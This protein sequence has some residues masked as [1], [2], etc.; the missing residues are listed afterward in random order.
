MNIEF[1]FTVCSQA[2]VGDPASLGDQAALPCPGMGVA[3]CLASL[4]C[5]L[6]WT[7]SANG[8]TLDVWLG[9]GGAP[10]EGIYHCTLDTETGRL[11]PARLAARMNAPGFLALHPAGSHLYAVGGWEGRPSVVAFRIVDQGSAARLE[12]VNALEIGD[13]GA[14]HL[15]VNSD[16][17]LLLTAQYGGGSVAAF[18]LRPDGSLDRRTQLEKHE[19]G[20]QVVPDRQRRPH[21]HWVG[22][23]PDERFALV[24][25]LGMDQVVVYR[26]D[27]A[28][29]T[30]E[31][32]GAGAVPP[33]GGPRHLRF[34]PN[35]QWVYVLNE[36]ALSVSVFQWDGALGQ[37]TLIQTLPTV[38]QDILALEQFSSCSEICVHPN[39]QFVYAANRGH[40]TITG[41]Q[42][43]SDGRL[44]EIQN[45]PIR[46]ATPRNFNIDPSGRWLLAAGQDSHTLASFAVDAESGRL[47]YNRSVI[48]T[49]TPIC[50]LF[51]G[52][53]SEQE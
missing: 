43:E 37:L 42:V 4:L 20:S 6:I 3:V 52:M 34:H 36:L 48:S 53:P 45:I 41:F 16:A 25:D 23:S 35:G 51:G 44:R 8:Q 40:D 49:P 27:A 33:G 1:S 46:G 17:R 32:H 5:V 38:E 22:F 12:F 18:H 39:G 2:S 29:G 11:S 14:T 10:S 26:V 9:T 28:A 15:A 21:P 30:L 31:R 7:S 50:V 24:P 47:T 13:G 19:G